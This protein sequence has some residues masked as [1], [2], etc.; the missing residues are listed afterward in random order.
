MV[1]TAAFC[2]IWIHEV[3]GHLRKSK[4]SGIFRNYIHSL[5]RAWL[6]HVSEHYALEQKSSYKPYKSIDRQTLTFL[7]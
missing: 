5:P 6:Q 2:G 7:T 1:N 4:I 3:L